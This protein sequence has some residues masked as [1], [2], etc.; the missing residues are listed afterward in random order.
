MSSTPQAHPY[1]WWS[2]PTQ[3]A[4]HAQAPAPMTKLARRPFSKPKADLQPG[5]GSPLKAAQIIPFP[6]PLK[7]EAT[8]TLPPMAAP[9]I[10]SRLEPR[11]SDAAAHFHMLRM[12]LEFCLADRRYDDEVYPTECRLR[13]QAAHIIGYFA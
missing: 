2:T 6:S 1:A 12:R 3:R 5:L 9:L 8:D 4:H 11:M 7:P 13:E 10:L